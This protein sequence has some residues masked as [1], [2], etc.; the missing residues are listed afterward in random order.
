M[1]ELLEN[2]QLLFTISESQ[3]LVLK[4]SVYFALFFFKL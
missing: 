3:V 1:T 2:L 4:I